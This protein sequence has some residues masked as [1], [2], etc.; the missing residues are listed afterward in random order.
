MSPAAVLAAALAMLAVPALAGAVAALRP[1]TPAAA[2]PTSASLLRRATTAVAARVGRR[3][4]I[5]AAL[6]GV[7]GLILAATSGWVVAIPILPALAVVLPRQL[8]KVDTRDIDQLE[9]VANWTKRVAGL[10]ASNK[11]LTEALKESLRS[12]PPAIQPQ[13]K[14]LVT[15]LNAHQPTVDAVYAFGKELDPRAG[16]VIGALV[17]A[18]GAGQ[19]GLTRILGSIS[20]MFTDEVR[21]LRRIEKER[22]EGRQTARAVT[23]FSVVML[24]GIMLTDYGRAYHSPLGQTILLV[25]AGMFFALLWVQT[26]MTAPPAQPRIIIAPGEARS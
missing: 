23:L 12:T 11:S 4:L 20:T 10:I 3:D 9:A 21:Q 17:L 7:L 16:P 13:V 24:T 25:L 19:T 5:A 1:A 22:A 26:A 18:A 6:G 8:A 2:K 15:R 14:L